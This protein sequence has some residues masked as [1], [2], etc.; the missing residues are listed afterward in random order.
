MGPGISSSPGGTERNRGVDSYGKSRTFMANERTF[1]AYLRTALTFLI[2]GMSFVRFFGH[3]FI[4][5][6]G[7]VFIPVGIVVLT[8]GTLRFRQMGRTIRGHENC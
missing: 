5:A 7:W 2:A 4:V 1:L 8:V 6:L 3:P